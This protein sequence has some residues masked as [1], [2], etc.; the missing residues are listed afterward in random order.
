MNGILSPLIGLPLYVHRVPAWPEGSCLQYGT[1]IDIVVGVTEPHDARFHV[2]HPSVILD[3]V[4]V[5][6]VLRVSPRC[7]VCIEVS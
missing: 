5:V 1:S 6:G 4:C 2:Q 3:D 7:G